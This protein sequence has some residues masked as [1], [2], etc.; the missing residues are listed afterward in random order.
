MAF[1]VHYNAKVLPLKLWDQTD[2][3]MTDAATRNVKNE[4]LIRKASSL[5]YFPIHLICKSHTV[6]ALDKSNIEILSK[7]EKKVK[8]RELFE[9][10][11]PALKASFRGRKAN[12]EAAMEALIPLVTQDK[13][14][15]SASKADLFD[16]TCN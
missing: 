9:H 5:N 7:I 2:V 6:E 8:Q 14:A 4:G 10:I 15:K 3:I 1:N 16:H 11:N 13:S 12:V